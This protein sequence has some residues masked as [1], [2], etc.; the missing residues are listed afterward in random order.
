[1]A[2]SYT[3]IENFKVLPPLSDETQSSLGTQGLVWS[4][5]SPSWAFSVHL[6]SSFTLLGP[7]WSVSAAQRHQGLRAFA[8]STSS[9]W[10]TL[11]PQILSC[12]PLSQPLGLCS[13]SMSSEKDPCTQTPPCPASDSFSIPA[14][15][16]ILDTSYLFT[17]C[18]QPER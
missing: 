16:I 3:V 2:I 7:H 10:N 4:G 15:W 6:S 5:I 18:P 8:L 9:A 11:F 17:D 14:T 12:H 1:M 13:T